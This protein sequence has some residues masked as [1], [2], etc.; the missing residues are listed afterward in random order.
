MSERRAEFDEHRQVLFAVAYR[1][2]GTVA[3]AEDMVQEAYLRWRQAPRDTIDSP[4]AYLTT[5][6]TRLCIDH[7]RSA[8]VKR[9][10]YIGPWLPEPVVTDSAP[11]EPVAMA[12]SLS[13]AFLVLLESLTPTE[14]A[15]ML[16]REVFDY[17]YAEIA[18]V[19]GKTEANCRQLVRR[20][21]E[22]L[23]ERRPRFAASREDRDRIVREFLEAVA[24]GD[25]D[26]LVGMLASDATLW[27]DGGGKV[28]AARNPIVG[29]DR[30]GRFLVGV[31]KKAQ[32]VI[33]VHP[34]VVNGEPGVLVAFG[35]RPLSVLTL[36][37]GPSGV[38]GVYIVSNPDKLAHLEA[39]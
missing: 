28:T 19:L 36:H 37:V 1:M 25:L 39:S 24:S 18:E 26:G 35:G 38:E 31:M 17:E 15:A 3:D 4:R 20:A 23:A 5:V 29:A 21:R 2:L 14:R 12:E 6:V 7:L 9:E 16:L 8:R 32:G 11:D 22:R 13:M 30:V 27:S 33:D 10:E 34:V